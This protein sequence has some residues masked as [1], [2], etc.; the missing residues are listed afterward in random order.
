MLAVAHAARPIVTRGSGTGLSGGSV[1]IPDG[2][3]I[4]LAQMDA[5]LE[6]DAANLTLRAQAGA[7]TLKIDEAAGRRTGSSIRPIPARCG[8]PPSAATS[9]RIPAACAA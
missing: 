2:L 3:V 1:P 5:I 6:V 8:S 9:P 7:I 4:C